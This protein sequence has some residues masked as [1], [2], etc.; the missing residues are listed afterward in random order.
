MPPPEKNEATGKEGL[1][2]NFIDQEK[3]KNIKDIIQ[4]IKKIAMVA[5]NIISGLGTLGIQCLFLVTLFGRRKEASKPQQDVMTKPL[6]IEQN[7][8]LLSKK[9]ENNDEY[10]PE[11]KT[12][13]LIQEQIITKT[14]RDFEEKVPIAINNL[15]T[16][17]I[18]RFKLRVLVE[19]KDKALENEKLKNYEHET[20]ENM[21]EYLELEKA[22]RQIHSDE[23][24]KL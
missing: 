20:F 11:G 19:Q 9:K 14:Q 24:D 18:D 17:I 6:L 7:P 2:N 23:K 22:K 21:Y 8:F 16:Q 1:H 4:S 3:R 10:E 13:N 12:E 5:F 15:Q